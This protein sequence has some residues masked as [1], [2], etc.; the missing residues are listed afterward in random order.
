MLQYLQATLTSLY[1]ADGVT[2]KYVY[3][4]ASVSSNS[5]NVIG[6]SLSGRLESGIG[7][8]IL[9]TISMPMKG[10]LSYLYAML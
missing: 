3:G 6:S 5:D 7:I 10:T 2:V 1:Y 8:Y 9:T 4:P